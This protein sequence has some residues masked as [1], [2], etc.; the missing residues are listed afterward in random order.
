MNILWNFYKRARDM[1]VGKTCVSNICIVEG[2]GR[3]PRSWTVFEVL[4]RLFLWES[5][6]T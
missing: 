2:F 1:G 5:P 4:H 6:V 3:L